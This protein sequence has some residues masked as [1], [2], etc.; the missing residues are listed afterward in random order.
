MILGIDKSIFRRLLFSCLFTVLLG[1]CAVGLLMS[2]LVKSYIVDSAK[3]DLLREAK[4]VNLAIQQEKTVN[5]NV[6]NLL[7]FFDQSYDTRI[8]LFDRQGNIV[9]MSTQDE[10]SIGKYVSSWIVS[11]V[12]VGGNVVQNLK[13][14]GMTQ[15]MVSVVVPW[16]KDDNVYGG[17]VLHAPITGIEET[18]RNLREAILWITLFGILL[19]TAMA[20]YLSWSI[21]RPL[22]S[23]DQAAAKIGMGEYGE[24][25]H[26][27][28]KDEIGELASTINSM[29]EK[30]EKVDGEKRRLEQTRQDFLANI[31]HELR[32]PLTAMQ[33]FL[34]ALLDDLIDEGSRH[35]YYDII[36][37]ES[38]HMN[39]LVDDIMELVKLENGEITLSKTRV[40]IVGLM[41]KIAF[42]FTPEAAEKQVDI[43]VNVAENLPMVYADQTRLEQILNNL[44][45]NAVKFTDSGTINLSADRQGDS[46]HLSVADTGIGIAVAD[47]ERIWERFFKVDRGRSRKNI[48][49]G[50]GLA[51]VRELVELHGGEI[52]LQSE[53]G[54][55]TT[56]H[57]LLPSA[58][59]G[60]NTP[61]SE[62]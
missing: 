9:A 12:L 16:G 39:R 25:I 27:Q 44:V 33:G 43:Q 22:R 61:I 19:S 8:W 30:L 2:L 59:A 5:D 17:I 34:E 11:K 50:L 41:N 37:H 60:G 54:Q 18:V 47:Q 48:G 6:R 55:G 21:S 13:F 57:I 1:L 42:K 4:K 62:P 46:L 58:E 14:E 56:F 53:V 35:K 15:P 28:S 23:I 7:V 45:K 10:V 40:D 49:S 52:G 38:L 31:S 26:I 20:S 29:A 24:R 32:T 51:I 3:E 36:Y